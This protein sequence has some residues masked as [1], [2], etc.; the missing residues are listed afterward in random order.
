ML[1]EPV[2]LAGAPEFAGAVNG[3]LEMRRQV[4]ALSA[5]AENAEADQNARPLEVSR[6]ALERLPS[7]VDAIAEDVGLQLSSSSA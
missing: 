2:A 1:G 3:A 5:L 7:L 4:M 6:E